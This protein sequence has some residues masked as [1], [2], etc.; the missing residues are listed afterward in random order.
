[1]K[2][3]LVPRI[4]V[5]ILT[6]DES[7]HLARAIES[8]KPIAHDILVV[9]SGSTDDTLA[10]AQEAG[11]SVLH[12]D[13][14]NYAFQFNW[15]LGMLS[16]ETEWVMRLDADEI[17][18]T[19]LVEE[20]QQRL[21]SVP[22]SVDGIDCGRRMCF[23]GKPIQWGGLFPIQVLRLF[24]HGK[25]HC[26]N[27]WMDEHIIVTGETCN[28]KG[29]IVDDNQK[30][31][32]W[33]TDKHNAYASREVIDLL[34]LE[35]GFLPSET[36]TETPGGQ[37][38]LKRRIKEKVYARLPVGMR[39]TLYFL[40]RYILRMGFMDGSAGFMFHFLQG[41]WYRCLVDAKLYEVKRYMQIQG[42]DV[43]SAV[44]SVLEIDISVL[45]AQES[46]PLPQGKREH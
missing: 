19:D 40:Y 14:V 31:L 9:D 11:A 12:N 21:A 38:G 22:S 2:K 13:W 17:L 15:A 44:K 37:A 5:V 42:V 7:L 20:I 18:T 8:V 36:L 27:R 30:S 32:T 28:F 6:R 16:A 41:Y 46:D 24:R 39:S 35:L 43:E 26:E 33:W 4:T 25:G 1:M 29:E 23:L 3:Y 45:P 34:N 10:I